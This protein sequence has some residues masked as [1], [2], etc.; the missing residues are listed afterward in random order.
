MGKWFT[1]IKKIEELRQRYRKLLKQYH[2]DNEGGSIEITQEINAEY[3]RLFDILSKEKQS[4]G[5]SS[6]YDTEAENEA[7]K[8]I[9]NEII[10]FNVEIEIIGSWIW[11]FNSYQ[12][13]SQLKELGFRYAAKKKAWVWHYGEYKRYHKGETDLNDIRAKYGSQKVNR[14]YKQFSLN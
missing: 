7:F 8:S 13:R 11:C 6:T 12:F 2:P 1:E 5:E 4:D 14:N 3:D 10:N 9:L